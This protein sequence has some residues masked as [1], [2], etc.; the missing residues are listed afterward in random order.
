MSSIKCIHCGL[1]NWAIA[2]ACKRCGNPPRGGEPQHEAYGWAEQQQQPGGWPPPGRGYHDADAKKRKGLATASLVLGV[3]SILTLTFFLV[4]ALTALILGI[5]ALVRIKNQ[6]ALYGGRGLA[7]AGIITSAASFVMAVPLAIIMAIAIP[8]LLASRQAAN[9]AAAVNSLRA[10]LYAQNTYSATTGNGQFGELNQLGS[11]QLIDGELASGRKY[12]YYFSVLTF[13]DGCEISA[14]P[15]NYGTTGR[16]SFQASCSEEDVRGA[17]RRGEPASAEDPVVGVSPSQ[18]NR[19]V[20]KLRR[21]ADGSF[22][23]ADE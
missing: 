4:G 13:E 12:G 20:I 3:I 14:V 2:P 18:S 10:I 17:D 21:T 7:L 5:V 8:N 23:R 16:R 1:V 11:V 19:R 15:Q 9:E 6:P 22:V